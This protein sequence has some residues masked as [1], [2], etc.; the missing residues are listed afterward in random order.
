MCVVEKAN[1]GGVVGALV[2]SLPFNHKVSGSNPGSA[3]G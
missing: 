1:G 3:E 2:R